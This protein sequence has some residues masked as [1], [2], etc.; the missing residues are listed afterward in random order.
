MAYLLFHNFQFPHCHQVAQVAFRAEVA[1]WAEVEFWA[2]VAFWAEGTFQVQVAFQV[3]VAFRAEVALW[4][5]M[6]PVVVEVHWFLC[7]SSGS[8]SPSLCYVGMEGS[9]PYD[10][11]KLLPHVFLMQPSSFCGQETQL[12]TSSSATNLV[13]V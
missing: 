1:F 9:H 13:S 10:F 4:A 7:T 12:L 3:E 11:Y 2:E 6:P 5:E 8:A